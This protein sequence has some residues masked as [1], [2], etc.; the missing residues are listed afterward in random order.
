MYRV[1]L[2]VDGQEFTQGL[3][4]EVDLTAPDAVVAVDAEEDEKERAREKA[5]RRSGHDD[6]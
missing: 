2:T 1:V 5:K 4:V 6:D 3:R